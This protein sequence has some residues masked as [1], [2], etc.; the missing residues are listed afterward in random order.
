MLITLLTH[1]REHVKKNNT[2]QLALECIGHV[3][4]RIIWQ[5][6]SAHPALVDAIETE[7]AALLYP[8]EFGAKAVDINTVE[9]FIIVDGTWQEAR[10]IYNK[11]PYLKKAQRLQLTGSKPSGF[12]L[13]RNQIAGGLC[14]AEC[15]IELLMIKQHYSEA[16]VLKS[17]FHLFNRR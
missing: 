2:G 1:E 15:I 4:E 14:T 5:R 9:H 11:S 8:T 13:R 12:I 10:K 3:V 7:Q 16:E 6:R 17:A